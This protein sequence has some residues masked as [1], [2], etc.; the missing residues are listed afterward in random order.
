MNLRVGSSDINWMDILI[1]G[2]PIVVALYVA[3]RLGLR[4]YFPPDT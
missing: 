2:L 1:V 4:H 3:V